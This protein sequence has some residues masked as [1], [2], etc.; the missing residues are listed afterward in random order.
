MSRD[1][2]TFTSSFGLLMTMLG[3]AVGLALTLLGLPFAVPAIVYSLFVYASAALVIAAGRLAS[4][5]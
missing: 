2:E 5:A 3:V 1:R 4:P